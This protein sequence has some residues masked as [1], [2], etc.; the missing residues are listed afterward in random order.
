GPDAAAKPPNSG[1]AKR[2]S[3][4]ARFGREGP[5]QARRFMIGLAGVL[6]QSP[7]LR[8]RAV[9]L[10]PRDIGRSVALG[11]V[12]LFARYRPRPIV[13]LD[14]DI[15]S[16]SVRY[17]RDDADVSVSQDQV[18]AELGALLY[19]GRGDVAQ[20]ALSG[21]VG[22]MYNLVRY[23]AFKQTG[24]Q[25]FGS[26]LLRVGAEAEFLLKRVAIVLSFRTYGVMTPRGNVRNSGAVLDT[27]S[28]E[29]RRAPVA[30]FSTMLLGS[31][32]IAYRF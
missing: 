16:G 32:G 18:L 12:G 9:Y 5:P 14:L 6:M 29:A 22:G 11:G 13:G 1:A 23:D 3:R 17:R 24:R 21:G 25:V 31:A 7:P 30:S 2:Q 4:L 15:R 20:F 19:L 8:V 10:D 26:A 28:A 27:A